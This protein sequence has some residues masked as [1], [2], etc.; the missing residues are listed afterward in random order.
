MSRKASSTFKF[1]IIR[2]AWPGD[3]EPG[4]D[5]DEDDAGLEDLPGWRKKNG[6][7]CTTSGAKRSGRKRTPTPRT[8]GLE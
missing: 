8:D 5:E 2:A 4:F 1:S 6:R 3:G 7:V